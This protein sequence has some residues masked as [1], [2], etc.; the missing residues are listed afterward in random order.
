[1]DTVIAIGEPLPDFAL[2]SLDGFV[3]RLSAYRGRLALVNFWSAECE[4]CRRVDGLLLPAL[5]AWTPQVQLIPIAANPGEP[6]ELLRRTAAECGLPFVLRDA[7]Q[8]VVALYGA[9]ATPHFFLAD[10][11]GILR[12]QGAFDDVTFRQRTP[13]RSYL[14]EAVQAL[15]SGKEP[16]VA[17]SAAY[18]CAITPFLEVK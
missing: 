5:A 10:R 13:T 15:L 16:P 14:V 9:Q 1:M 2:P 8:E 11:E 12:Y 18:G 3:H 17:H 6:D 4:W 7:R